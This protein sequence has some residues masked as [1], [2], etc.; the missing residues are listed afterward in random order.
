M[1]NVIDD[2]G[3]FIGRG[4][5]TII[6]GAADRPPLRREPDDPG[7]LPYGGAAWLV[8]GDQSMLVG[9]VRALLL[10]TLHP[11]VMSGVAQHSDYKRDP[12]GRLQRTGRFV[13]ETTFGTLEQAEQ[14]LAL[15]RS[16]H[17]RVEGVTPA[18]K[19]YSASDPRLLEWVHVTEVDSFL[20]AHQRFGT[21]PA[22][23]DD[24]DAY[25][26]EMAAVGE[27]LGVERAPRD[28]AEL[29][30]SLESFRPEL[31]VDRQCREAIRWLMFP[32]LPIPARPA[33]GV[34]LSASIGFLP[35]WARRMMW[36]PKAPLADP[37]IVRPTTT[38]M[39]R[40][41]GW[42]FAVSFDRDEQP[43]EQ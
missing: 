3:E 22:N 43:P 11:A 34:L 13:G 8:H 31:V 12:L 33:Y 19:S 9:G 21:H 30:A 42:A 24:A 35:T 29:A 1:V 6:S 18:G 28:R 14:S 39:L 32:P 41:L 16:I 5:R 40:V 15:V 23:D 26:E 25:I 37:L 7:L 4:V 20:R 2:A 38:A 36:L 10:Q 27:G 17:T